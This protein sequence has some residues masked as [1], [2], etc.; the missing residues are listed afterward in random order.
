PRGC[1]FADFISWYSPKDV[2]AAAAAA[3]PAAGTAA[4]A[5]AHG[6]DGGSDGSGVSLSARMGSGAI[7]GG[8]AAAAAS[9]KTA[10]ATPAAAAAASAA[11]PQVSNN[12][13]RRLWDSTA[14]CPVWTQ[15]PLQD[16]HLEGERVLHE[17][18]TLSP[19][20]LY[21]TLLALA[22]AAAVQLLDTSD[23]GSLPPVASLLRQYVR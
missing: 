22:L 13:W 3:T 23:G 17:L 15:K 10:V 5:A 2:A 16:P 7:S 1:S 20:H 4:D 14:A 9:V 8:S 11:T 18:E 12:P 19:V 6:G 21:D